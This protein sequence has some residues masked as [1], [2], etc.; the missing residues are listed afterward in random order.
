MTLIILQETEGNKEMGSY[1]E[2]EKY[3]LSTS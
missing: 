3:H 1:N 2:N